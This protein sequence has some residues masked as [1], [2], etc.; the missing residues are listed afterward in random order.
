MM[1][2]DALRSCKCTQCSECIAYIY[3]LCHCVCDCCMLLQE[4][5]PKE[6]ND[7]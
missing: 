7:T 6:Q 5:F 1:E 3:Y 4:K 2:L